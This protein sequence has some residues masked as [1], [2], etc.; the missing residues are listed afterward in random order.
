MLSLASQGDTD[1]DSAI[2]NIQIPSEPQQVD[3]LSRSVG[4]NK[5]NYSIMGI[6]PLFHPKTA[7]LDHWELAGWL[8]CGLRSIG[9]TYRLTAVQSIKTEGWLLPWWVSMELP[10]NAPRTVLSALTLFSWGSVKRVLTY[11]NTYSTTFKLYAA[12]KWDEKVSGGT[13]LLFDV[14]IYMYSMFV[15][16]S[17]SSQG[18]LPLLV[19]SIKISKDMKNGKQNRSWRVLLCCFFPLDIDRDIFCL[20]YS[21]SNWILNGLN[22]CVKK[23]LNLWSTIKLRGCLLNILQVLQP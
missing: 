16:L 21:Y 4:D 8:L 5:T 11:G 14:F 3:S 7:V 17:C 6:I 2:A 1:Y 12:W 20:K 9:H 13:F 22:W 10:Q 15:C 18:P 19:S 23:Y